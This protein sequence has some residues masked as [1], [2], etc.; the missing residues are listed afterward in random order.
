M[1]GQ[2]E[3]AKVDTYV[4]HF[5]EKPESEWPH[6]WGLNICPYD[7]DSFE[8]PLR[9]KMG[10]FLNH[11]ARIMGP[12]CYVYPLKYLHVTV[13]PPALFTSTPIKDEADQKL[14]EQE[15]VARLQALV[16]EKRLPP[17][18]TL[19]YRKMRLSEA[20]GFFL[21]RDEPAGSVERIRDVL[22]EV[23]ASVTR[24]YPDKKFPEIHCPNIV[25]TTFLRFIRKVD[26]KDM[27]M[28]FQQVEK[29]WGD[30]EYQIQVDSLVLIRESRPYMH[31]NNREQTLLKI[32]LRPA[33]QN[34]EM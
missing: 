10:S 33:Q 26:M 27:R 13:G 28:R 9:S 22:R 34:E 1:E 8:E 21:V 12:D 20:A 29:D 7:C 18:F 2:E 15:W 19:F 24:D 23:S 32:H 14:M 30:E 25:H 17:R 31:Q 4:H 16:A 3:V 11:V 6:A 5:V